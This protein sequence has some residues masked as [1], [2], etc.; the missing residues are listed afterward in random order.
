MEA[1]IETEDE[2]KSSASITSHEGEVAFNAIRKNFPR[3]SLAVTRGMNV[4][5]FYAEGLIDSTLVDLMTSQSQ[6]N[7]N[8]GIMVVRQLQDAVRLKKNAFS[9]IVDILSKEDVSKDVALVLKGMYRLFYR[10]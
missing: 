2:R 3:L 6:T 4:P 9:T 10:L 1:I 8:I 7:Q 5:S